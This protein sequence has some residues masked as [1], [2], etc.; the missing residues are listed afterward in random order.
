MEGKR[1]ET[2]SAAA[3]GSRNTTHEYR[4]LYKKNNAVGREGLFKIE[5]YNGR[6]KI[7]VTS[8]MVKLL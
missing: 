4:L 2:S 3:S 7:T 1:M 6:K 5:T 8:M